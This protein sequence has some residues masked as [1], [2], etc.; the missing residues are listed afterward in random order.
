[1]ARIGIFGG[2]FNP[3]HNGH[4]CLAE[5]YLNA[6]SLDKIL[7]IPTSVPPHKTAQHLA[8]GKDRMNMLKSAVSGN[9]KFETTDIELM[10]EGKSYSFDTITQ[11]KKIYPLD[12]LFLIVG[13]DQFFSF[14]SWYRADDILSMV[15][16]VT[17]AREK[18]E[19]KALLD[20]KSQH[21][22]MKNTIVSNFSVI[23]VSSSEIRNKI[24]AGADI[25]ALVPKAAADYIKEN[26][27][28]V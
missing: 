12:E 21:D 14:Q 3:V 9:D 27:L 23:E 28:Y 4:I 13:S 26:K 8:S 11:L 17:A 20:F 24:K 1:M 18:N 22:N 25:S 2:A 15:T 16:V 19:Y 6:L 10:R 5:N 7:F